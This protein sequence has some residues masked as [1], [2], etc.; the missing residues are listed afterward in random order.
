M[1]QLFLIALIS[2]CS[3]NLMLSQSVGI[4]TSTPHTSAQ[5]DITST[6]KGFLLPRM[7]AAQRIAIV[8]PAIGLEVYQTDGTKGFYYFDGTVWTL[9]GPGSSSGWSM[10]GNTAIDPSVNYIGTTD[11][12]PLIGK[13]NGEQVFRF[14]PNNNNMILG[15]QA[16][17][18][19][20]EGGTYNHIVGYRAG[21]NNA[22][23]FS[24]FDGLQ[25]GYN[26]YGNFNQF[27]GYNAGYSN[28]SGAGNFFNGF[29]AGYSNTTGSNNLV[30][31]YQAGY[32]N[33]TNNENHIIGYQAGFNNTG[34]LNHFV[35]FQAGYAN[36]TGHLN[37]FE[38]YKAGT[39][40]TTG[41]NNYFSGYGAGYSNNQSENHFCGLNAGFN[42]TTGFRNQFI[43]CQS[44]SFN[45]SG[46]ANVFS[47]FQSGYSNTIGN[48]NTF[49]GYQSGYGHSSGDNNVFTGY[50]SGYNDGVG[51]Y[52]TFTGYQSGSSH[53]SGDQN[54]FYGFR[55]GY[56][57]QTGVGNV[58][59][60]SQ[61]GFNETGSNRLYISN[62][63]ITYP[64]IYG[65]FDNQLLKVNGSAE[66]KKASNTSSPVL[67]LT[68][69]YN[70]YSTLRFKKT[71]A[72]NFS[73]DLA[74]YIDPVYQYSAELRFFCNGQSAMVLAGDGDLWVYGDLYEL[75][76]STLKTNI[77]PLQ[78]ALSGIQKINGVTYD[79]KN[80]NEKDNKNQIGFLAQ[81]VEQVFPQ[82]VNTDKQGEKTVSYTHMVPV[83]LEAIKEQQ[84]EIDSL[85]TKMDQMEKMIQELYRAKD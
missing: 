74:A 58:F 73:W 18:S 39:S 35:G 71:N 1:K 8:T 45:I 53:T 61:A 21:Y 52:N 14:T 51:S 25:A 56:N 49:T 79:W 59:L 76:D 7:T 32:K 11:V 6:S 28:T 84:T 27:I 78:N 83:L 46:N 17:H 64:L 75:S 67:E 43:G 38:G 22:G 26:N 57:N 66:I 50:Q 81:D 85:K 69:N 68:E 47:G 37:F 29:A 2:M 34:Q 82:L 16:S 4:G 41:N 62:S 77:K 9:L 80:K 10:T 55:S 33:V 63:N 13:A 30:I 40:N 36:T 44:G 65:E 24:H 3:V 48:N 54:V 20:Y 42:N 23:A 19:N 70:F 60:G 12:Q 5:M 15:Y 72:P 31:G